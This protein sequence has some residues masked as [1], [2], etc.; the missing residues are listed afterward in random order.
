[1]RQILR[2]LTTSGDAAALVV[3]QS[4][5]HRTDGVTFWNA[6]KKTE[7]LAAFR[8]AVQLDPTDALARDWL[9]FTLLGTN[10]PAAALPVAEEAVRLDPGIAQAHWN[11]GRARSGTDD[12]DGSITAFQEAVRLNPQNTLYQQSLVE[13]LNLRG[14]RTG[15]WQAPTPWSVPVVDRTD[16]KSLVEYGHALRGRGA[17]ERAAAAYREA[18]VLDP[19]N[20]RTHNFLGIALAADKNYTATEACYREAIRLDPSAAV[21]HSN[22]GIVLRLQERYPEAMAAAQEA[23]KRDPKYAPAH[24][25]IGL[26]LQATGDLEGAKAALEEAARL[27][28]NRYGQ[29]PGRVPRRQAP[30]PREVN[31]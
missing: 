13:A 7:A 18:I 1:M 9:A 5:R 14:E 20:A 11:L 19:K 12:L 21:F 28:P 4:R 17:N 10:D 22:L 29:L 23:L 31:P 15:I 6:G 24:A 30:P 2:N 8:E 25:T 16:P 3:A 26:S 27:D